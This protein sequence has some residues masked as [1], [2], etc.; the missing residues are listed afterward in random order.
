MGFV[1]FSLCNI[2]IVL[3]VRDE[4]RSAFNR[5]FLSDRRQLMLFGLSLLFVFVPVELGFPR[6]LGLTRLDGN[7]VADLHRVRGAGAAGGRSDQGLQ[8]RRRSKA[9][10]AAAVLGAGAGIRVPCL[11]GRWLTTGWC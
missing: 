1:A 4:N 8:A 7:A 5:D 2:T 6:F 11:R 3:S 10:P 9:K